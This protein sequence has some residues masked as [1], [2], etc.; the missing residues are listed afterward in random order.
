VSL[1]A[2]DAPTLELLRNG[3]VLA[4]SIAPRP[5]EKSPQYNNYYYATGKLAAQ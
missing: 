3:R 2:G 4:K 5:V 1:L